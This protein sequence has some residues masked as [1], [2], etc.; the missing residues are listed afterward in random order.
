MAAPASALLAPDSAWAC[1][2]VLPPITSDAYWRH[3]PSSAWNCSNGLPDP[4]KAMLL[5]PDGTLT[6]PA[7]N[8]AMPATAM[9]MSFIRP[10]IEPTPAAGPVAT[11]TRTAE[12]T[13]S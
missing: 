13:D 5:G 9:D 11:A 10:L 6:Q 1:S 4:G 2:A 12:R 7:L 3:D 8:A